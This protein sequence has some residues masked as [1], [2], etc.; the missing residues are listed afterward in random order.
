MTLETVSASIKY[1][2]PINVDRGNNCLWSGPIIILVTWGII[3][4]TKPITPLT[5]TDDAVSNAAAVRGDPFSL[6][7]STPVKMQSLLP[8]AIYLKPLG[9]KRPWQSPK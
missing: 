6:S 7:V 3:K 1:K 5:A 2:P 4:P 8:V 9:Y